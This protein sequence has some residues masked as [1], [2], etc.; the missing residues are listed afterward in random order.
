MTSDESRNQVAR[1]S[2]CDNCGH[3]VELYTPDEDDPEALKETRQQI[4]EWINALFTEA[5]HVN[6][7]HSPMEF[8]Q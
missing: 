1:T 2:D 7:I 4:Y 3:C 6:H 8:M 5:G